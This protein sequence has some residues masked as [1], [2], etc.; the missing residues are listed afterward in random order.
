[1]VTLVGQTIL[2]GRIMVE[3][4][5]P[6]DWLHFTVATL[7][8]DIGYLRGVCPGDRDGHYVIDARGHHDRGA[9]RRF[10][11]IPC[12]LPYRARQDLRPP[13]LRNLIKPSRRRA[14]RPGDRADPLSDPGG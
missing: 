6:E 4:V 14:D 10:G 2:R 1:M 12:A 9:A 3:E 5:T 11:R 8:H 7:C 13:P